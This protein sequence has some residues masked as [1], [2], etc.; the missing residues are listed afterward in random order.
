[1]SHWRNRYEKTC[2]LSAWSGEF[3]VMFLKVESGKFQHY[4]HLGH[5]FK[6]QIPR[7]CQEL[8]NHNFQEGGLGVCIFNKPPW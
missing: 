1:M 7:P 4:I 8:L 2:S 6:M 3:R 5:F